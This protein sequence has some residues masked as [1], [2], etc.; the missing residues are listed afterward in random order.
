[1]LLAQRRTQRQITA[2]LQIDDA[3][4]VIAC[5]VD[6]HH[7]HAGL[8]DKAAQGGDQFRLLHAG[9]DAG[10]KI[11]GGSH[12]MGK[13]PQVIT[14]RG[15]KPISAEIAVQHV[16][17]SLA[18]AVGDAVIGVANIIVTRDRFTNGTRAGQS[19]VCHHRKAALQA[20][21]G[22]A[23][24]R[25]E[26]LQQPVGDPG[27]KTLFQPQIVPPGWRHQVAEPHVRQLMRVDAEHA[28]ASG[29]RGICRQKKSLFTIADRRRQLGGATGPGR[30]GNDVQLAKRIRYAQLGLQNV[31]ELCADV[32]HLLHGIDLAAPG[33]RTQRNVAI[34]DGIGRNGWIFAHVER[35][36]RQRQQVGRH[37]RGG[38]E[39]PAGQA[40]VERAVTNH[41]RVADRLLAVGNVQR[42]LER[43]LEAGLV[44][45]RQILARLN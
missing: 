27:G 11:F 16:Q 24:F 6:P 30:G 7:R 38:H 18:F 28:K 42:D 17:H 1:M 19:V 22:M 9:G 23:L 43:C 5:S 33:H 39:L 45:T 20:I 34:A 37:R 25:L 40:I 10:V 32:H 29:G 41:R 13:F 31:D 2:L 14:Q 15:T 3:D 4:I 36:H 21:Q 44:K 8:L 35:P 26:T 12:V